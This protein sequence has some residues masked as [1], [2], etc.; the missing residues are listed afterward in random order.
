MRKTGFMVLMALAL[1]SAAGAQTKMSGKAHCAKGDP[2]HAIEVGDAAG[3]VLTLRKAACT[4]SEGLEIAGLKAKSGVDVATGEVTGA[5]M[6]DNGYHTATMDNG[7][8]FTVHFTGTAKMNKDNSGT[9]DGKWSFVSGTGKL[10]GI[11][12]SGTYKG[13]A[14]ADGSSDVSVDGDYTMAAAKTTPTKA[15]GDK[16]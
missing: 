8:T 4:W 2:D 12:G 3:H 11:K 15:P 5:T 16:K 13:T 6:R 14:A 7:D 9:F 1:A 10:K